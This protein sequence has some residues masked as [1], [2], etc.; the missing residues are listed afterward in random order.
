MRDVENE[1]IASIKLKYH[2]R[3]YDDLDPN[4]LPSSLIQSY[5][6]IYRYEEPMFFIT[7]SLVNHIYP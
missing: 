3:D 4:G 6:W 7:I 5:H 2:L 1:Q